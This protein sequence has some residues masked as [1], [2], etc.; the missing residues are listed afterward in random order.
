MRSKIKTVELADISLRLDCKHKGCRTGLL[1]SSASDTGKNG[2][3]LNNCPMCKEPW[4]ATGGTTCAN[5]IA[6][7][8]TAL[9]R[10]QS[11][12]ENFQKHFPENF[13]L[14]IE[15]KDEQKPTG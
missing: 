3:K 6:G 11:E 9:K 10:L 13:S 12:I 14:T 1:L 15:V 7:F 4:A 5:E 8:L 2:L